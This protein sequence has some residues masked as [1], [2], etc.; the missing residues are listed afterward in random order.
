M[1]NVMIKPTTPKANIYK[2]EDGNSD[3]SRIY[4]IAIRR[5]PAKR[6]TTK[7]KED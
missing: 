4:A 2:S 3:Q 6:L 5:A 1:W 7:F